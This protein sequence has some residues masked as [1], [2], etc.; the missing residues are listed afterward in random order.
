MLLYAIVLFAL[1]AVGGLYLASRHWQGNPPPVAVALIHGL[2]AVAGLVIVIMVVMEGG[3]VGRL[4]IAIGLFAV[5]AIGGLVL[6][7]LHVKG[8]PLPKPLIAAHALLAVSGFILV[9][10]TYLG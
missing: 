10:L 3:D 2:L 1:A 4:P 9:L 7:S 5:A 6:F 8:R